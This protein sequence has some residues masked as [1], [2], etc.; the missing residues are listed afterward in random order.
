[1]DGYKVTYTAA[2]N[3]LIRNQ[4]REFAVSAYTVQRLLLLFSLILT[5]LFVKI[6]GF[7]KFVCI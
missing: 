2:T 5:N 7:F 3:N 6:F 1:M 4:L